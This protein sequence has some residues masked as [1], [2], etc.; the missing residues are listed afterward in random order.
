[1]IVPESVR[2]E[3]RE[4]L[5][6]L[7]DF[8][9]FIS[10][11]GKRKIVAVGDAVVLALLRAKIE[12]FVSVFDFSTRRNPIPEKERS[13]LAAKYP[14]PLVCENPAGTIAEALEQS[15]KL[16]LKTG[17]A[18][19]IVGEEDLAALVFMRLCPDA[20][21]IVYGQPEKGVVAIECN[22]ASRRKAENF[23]RKIRKG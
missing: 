23:F 14:E 8:Q 21:I 15:A 13:E 2:T 4:P 22:E 7:M 12:S 3:L 10:S 1:M 16:V 9:S 6:S 20:L 17:G 18:L 19:R 5:G 11:Y